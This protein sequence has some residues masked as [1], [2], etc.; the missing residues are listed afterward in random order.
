MYN[1]CEFRKDTGIMQKYQSF[2]EELYR[3]ENLR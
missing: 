1:A 3:H 2:S